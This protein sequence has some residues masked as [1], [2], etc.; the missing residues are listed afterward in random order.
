MIV[1]CMQLHVKI[2]LTIRSTFEEGEME[3]VPEQLRMP[4][5]KTA[6]G[7]LHALRSGGRSC[8]LPTTQACYRLKGCGNYVDAEGMRYPYPGLPLLKYE[9]I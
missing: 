8:I 3:G 5:L 4:L 7:Q 1:V 6:D 9:V 2:S